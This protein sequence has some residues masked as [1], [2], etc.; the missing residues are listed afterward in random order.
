MVSR[1]DI[2]AIL[3]AHRDLGPHYDEQLADQLWT[4]TRQ[5]TVPSEVGGSKL[6][7]RLVLGKIARPPRLIWRPVVLLLLA[8]P[9]TAVAGYFG[10]TLGVIA[11]LLIVGLMAFFDHLWSA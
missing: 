6:G 7:M 2:L 10:S 5:G 4:L 8:I 9:L 3:R 11:S 1:D